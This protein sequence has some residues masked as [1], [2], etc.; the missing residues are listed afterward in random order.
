MGVTVWERSG[1]ELAELVLSGRERHLVVVSRKLGE[2]PLHFDAAYVAGEVGDWADVVVIENGQMTEDFADGLP[3]TWEVWGNAAR[4]YR[5]AETGGQRGTPTKYFTPRFPRDLPR[6]TEDLID[7]VLRLPMPKGGAPAA[8]TGPLPVVPQRRSGTVTGFIGEGERAWVELEDGSR[9]H[10]RQADV[11][12]GAR[13]DWLLA[14][15]QPVAGL[16]D[17]DTRV[18]DIS[19]SVSRPRLAK[20]YT[21]GQVVLCLVESA[22]ADRAVLSPLPGESLTIGRAEISSNDLDDVDSLLSPG[23]VVPARLVQNKGLKRLVLVDVDDDEP[24]VPCPAF[25]EG[26]L[27]WLELGRDLLPPEEDDGRF[28][29]SGSAAVE[30]AAVPVTGGGTSAAPSGPAETVDPGRALRTALLEIDSLK[31]QLRAAGGT[32]GVGIPNPARTEVAEP[33]EDWAVLEQELLDQLRQLTEENTRLQKANRQLTKQR[34]DAQERARKAVRSRPAAERSALELFGTVEE[35]LRHEVHSAW[36]GRI[37]PAEKAD[38]PLASYRV[39]PK[40]V[41][42]YFAQ[43]AEVRSKAAKALVDL[44]VGRAG[45]VNG[46]EVHPLR[47]GLGG[48]NPQ[49]ARE[50]GALCF[51]MAVENNVPSARRVHFWKLP[52]GDIELHEVVLHDRYDV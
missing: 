7:L 49:Q 44:L 48:N 25:V 23:Q 34:N 5:Y 12:P 17:P 24:V 22:E 39:G 3:L 29:P 37:S 15:G 50:D 45:Y 33:G 6:M 47:T 46:R 20:A 42:S 41:E 52:D 40:F 27:P 30:S 10:I 28:L 38:L 21:W 18:L 32:S 51:R 8:V 26:G 43:P 35:A 14:K 2:E 13:L 31:A 11:V 36:V 19:A 1:G 16:L 9:A 4:A